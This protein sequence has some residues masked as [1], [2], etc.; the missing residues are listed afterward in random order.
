MA[1]QV[2]KTTNVS[3]KIR[4]RWVIVLTI[5]A[6]TLTACDLD[7]ISPA[8]VDEESIDSENSIEALW[9]GILGQVSHIATGK[10]ANGGF[11]TFG[12]L[13][14]DETVHSGL[15]EQ[16]PHFRPFSDGSPIQSDWEGVE[17]LW[18]Q[19]MLTRYVVDFGVKKAREIYEKYEN[20]P[21]STIRDRVTRDRMRTYAWG[22]IAY[23]ILGDN[24]CEAVIDGGPPEPHT[25]FYERGL[26]LLDEGL[27]FAEAN[28]VLEVDQLGVRS[29]HAARAQ[30]RMMLGDW[31]GAVEDAARVETGFV[32]L[33]TGHTTVEPAHRQ[34]NWLRFI[35]FLDQ[36]FAHASGGGGRNMTLWGTPFLEWGYYETQDV[37]NDIRVSYSTHR[38]NSNP[39][40]EFGGDA[41]RPWFR[42]TKY[43][44]NTGSGLYRLAT[45][46]EMRLIEAE[47]MLR[48]GNW[49]GAIDKINE[50]RE[51]WN[52]LTGGQ[53]ER[54]GHPLP[55]IS[56]SGEEEAW[57]LLMR[58]R[59]IELWLE[60][61]RLPDMRRW[62]ESP[63]Y[64]PFEVVREAASG[65]P[66]N[67]PKRNVL[68]IAGEFCIPI[69]ATE[70]RLN[71]NL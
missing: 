71:P 69:G 53:L 52:S 19:S 20:D 25:V 35:D 5:A 50:L 41:R 22:G 66:E 11:F 30:I 64:V 63:G 42:Q 51:W 31:A 10:A 16:F 21:L 17:E 43:L 56:A 4:V 3:S 1:I 59:G 70:Y 9:S 40:R 8:T 23:R 38:T 49:P 29:A 47:A 60:G 58:E 33:R 34:Y 36:P 28:N 7:V 44:S 27:E 62:K 48:Q 12:A 15:P 6:S 13:R 32:G 46:H 54:D 67:D 65:G 18:N 61:R 14:T 57:E 68:D 39:H 45:G 2:S 26:A 24:L 55:M 37:G